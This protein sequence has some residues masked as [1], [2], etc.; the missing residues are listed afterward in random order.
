MTTEDLTNAEIADRLALFAALLELS[1]ASP[2]AVRA[3]VRAAD[4]VRS[5]PGSV[6]ALVRSGRI[7]DLRGIGT[8]I[9]ARLEELVA[10][11]E[12]A[13][14]RELEAET[15]PELVGY[16]RML[17]IG[18]KRMLGLARGLQVSTVDEFRQAVADGRLQG[19]PG[20]GPATEESIRAALE[21]RPQ[22]SRGLTLERSL[23]LSA[24]L[25]ALLGGA[26][27]G[28][29]RRLCELSDELVVVCASDDPAGMLDRFETQPQIV[30]VLE[31]TGRRALALTIDGVPVTLVVARPE[32]FGT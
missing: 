31:R 24:E 6:A 25:A 32:T 27:A 16:G 14:L 28:Q 8:G 30:A 5:T 10:T 7:R 23:A 17:G 20:I 13:E 29:A 3:Y 9:G 4:L 12:I 18:T 21:R 11:G 2:F 22:A 1:E 19:V 15:S 26:V